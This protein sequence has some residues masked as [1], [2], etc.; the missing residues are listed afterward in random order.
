MLLIYLV[1]KLLLYGTWCYVGMRLFQSPR[2]LAGAS[3]SLLD[4]NPTD[5]IE[6]VSP[7]ASAIKALGLG[8]FRLAIGLV[9]GTIAIFVAWAFMAEGDAFDRGVLAYVC[10]L[11]PVRALEWWMTARMIGR[12]SASASFLWVFGGVV[13]SCLAD[14][15]TSFAVVDSLSGLC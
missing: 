6:R 7:T 14:I 5:H 9:F 12:T 1:G 3:L 11:V 2:L 8:L 4:A 15:P 13:L 10:F